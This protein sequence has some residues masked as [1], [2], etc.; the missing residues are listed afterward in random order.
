LLIRQNGDVIGDAAKC[1]LNARELNRGAW[2]D[3]SRLPAEVV[4]VDKYPGAAIIRLYEDESIVWIN[5]SYLTC[6]RH[7]LT[8]N[9]IRIF[10]PVGKEK[11]I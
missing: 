5:L 7:P 6:H 9:H 10:R 8:A 1:A 3:V 11:Y 2:L 4:G